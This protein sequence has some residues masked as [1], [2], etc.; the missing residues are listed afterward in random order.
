ML[1]LFLHYFYSYDLYGHAKIVW[2]VVVVVS[3]FLA[4]LEINSLAT[5]YV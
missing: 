3:S 4:W 2:K 1:F 5:L